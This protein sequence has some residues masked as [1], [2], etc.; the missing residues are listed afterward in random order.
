MREGILVLK[1]GSGSA[2]QHLVH[3]PENMCAWRP[4]CELGK[5]NGTHFIGGEAWEHRAP[6]RFFQFTK[7]ENASI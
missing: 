2:S 1:E 3:L 4:S 7:E 6:M 5:L